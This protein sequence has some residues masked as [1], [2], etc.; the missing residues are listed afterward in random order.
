MLNS[1]KKSAA[2]KS[3]KSKTFTTGMVV[4]NQR[5]QGQLLITK[6][7]PSYVYY[8]EP[9]FSGSPVERRA[10][11]Q[12]ERDGSQTISGGKNSGL[13]YSPEFA[14]KSYY[15]NT[16]KEEILHTRV[17]VLGDGDY[18]QMIHSIPQSDTSEVAGTLAQRGWDHYVSS[19]H[20]PFEMLFA[21]LLHAL[22][23][24]QAAQ[25]I[26]CG[27]SITLRKGRKEETLE[28]S[29]RIELRDKLA[30]GWKIAGINYFRLEQEAA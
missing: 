27:M 10:K 11:I 2:Q 5:N 19:S 21:H 23:V 16:R 4:T 25:G 26:E 6:V 12:T 9:H 15:W 29:D 28:L 24:V 7:T 14:W 30:Q 22:H 18:S 13:Y 3:A 20:M 17:I 1:T 8:V